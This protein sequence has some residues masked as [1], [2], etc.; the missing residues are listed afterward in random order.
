MK[1][2]CYHADGQIS[3]NATAVSRQSALSAGARQNW[4]KGF[5]PDAWR[6]FLDNG[7]H[8]TAREAY[9]D[10]N[11]FGWRDLRSIA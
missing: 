8:I 9:L 3:H 10:T 5:L 7:K 1:I 11:F 6:I 2:T 4:S